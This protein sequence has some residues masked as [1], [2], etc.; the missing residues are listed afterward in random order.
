MILN[1]DQTKARHRCLAPIYDLA[2]WGYRL[3]CASRHRRQA[4]EPLRLQ[5]GAT[6]VD[7]TIFGLAFKALRLL[8]YNDC[9]AS[10]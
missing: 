3:P 10:P 1:R 2:L 4:V 7:M 6:V 9:T 5:P 8:A